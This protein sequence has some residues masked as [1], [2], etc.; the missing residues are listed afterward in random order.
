[1]K[2]FIKIIEIW[3]PNKEHTHLVLKDGIYGRFEEFRGV[4]KHKEFAYKQGLPGVVWSSGK[5][6]VLTDF[7]KSYFER[8]KHA[9]KTGL[10]CAIGLPIFS[11]EFLMSVIVFLCG[12][13]ED[14]AGAIE[15]WSNDPDRNNELGVI[16][17]YYGTLEYFEFISRKTKIMKG[18][19]LPGQVWEK[20]Q[21]ILMEDLGESASFIRGRDAKNAGITTGLGLPVAMNDDKVYIMTFLSA[22]MTPIA[23][24]IQLWQ[25]DEQ[26][27]KLRCVSACGSE[28]NEL[29]TIFE[30]KTFAKG[31]GVI[32]AAWLGGVPVI[33]ASSFT[34]NLADP[35]NISSILAMPIIDHGKLV[36]VATFLF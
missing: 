6:V 17:G 11:G 28:N 1:M 8:T 16:D 3:V 29:A 23:K 32:G 14:H 13:D 31:E 5:P 15:V 12:D 7:N 20:K 2:T 25:P 24:R 27:G 4:S 30:S 22:K 21:P 36:A 35:A 26:H 33:G 10:T 19:G 18:F 9:Q 34:D